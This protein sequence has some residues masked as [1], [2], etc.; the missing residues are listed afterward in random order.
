MRY[1]FLLVLLTGCDE[2]R[3]I[4]L[5]ADSHYVGC[6]QGRRNIPAAQLKPLKTCEELRDAFELRLHRPLE[7]RK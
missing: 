1:L 3:V 4:K 6:K 7:D 5:L 2:A